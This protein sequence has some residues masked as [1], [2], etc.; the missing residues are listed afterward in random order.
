M[1]I[2]DILKR[3]AVVGHRGYP[4]KELENTLPSLEAAIKSGADIVEADVQ[5][6]ADGVVVLSHDDTL[7][8]TFGVFLNVRTATWEEVRRVTKGRVPSLREALELVAERAGVFVEVKHPEDAAAV[9]RVIKE[10]GAA[11]WA[12]VI[13]FHDQAL[14]QVEGYKGL[15]YAKPPGRVLDAKKLKC[16]IVLPRYTLATEKAI[17]LAHKLGLYVVVWTVNDPATAAELWK[18]GVDGI[19]TDD[20]EAILKALGRK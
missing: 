15:V 6:T 7:E 17:S 8:R 13:S 5:M 11:R 16:H 18:R 9:W 12:A 14:A 3:R 4:V 1:D 10:A 20:V 19:A 2:L